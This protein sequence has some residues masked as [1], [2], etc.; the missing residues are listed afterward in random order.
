MLAAACVSPVPRPLEYLD[1]KTAATVTT[2]SAPLVFAR[3]RPDLASNARDYATVAAVNVNRSGKVEHL[4]L[5][6]LWS[7]VDPRVRPER[8]WT[9]QSVV[10][11]ADDRNVIFERDSRTPI[12]AGISR[13]LH[14]PPARDLRAQLYRVDPQTLHFI[15][16]SQRLKLVLEDKEAAGAFYLWQDGRQALGDFLNEAP[17]PSSSATR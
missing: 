11:L 16:T 14:A 17:Q 6:Y 10:L 7:T 8:E 2:A 5:V 15:A 4:L 9:A 1:E 13:P 3:D 12:Q